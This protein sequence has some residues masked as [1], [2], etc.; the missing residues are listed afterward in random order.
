[1]V[2]RIRKGDPVI[3]LNAM[4][5][6]TEKQCVDFPKLGVVVQDKVVFPYPVILSCAISLCIN[7][8]SQSSIVSSEGESPAIPEAEKVEQFCMMQ[9][10]DV[11]LL[12]LLQQK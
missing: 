7:T 6:N 2:I 10:A 4:L 5:R 3:L 11:M 9:Y 12:L 1:M 8:N